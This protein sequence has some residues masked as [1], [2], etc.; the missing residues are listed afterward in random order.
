M[1][2]LGVGG[3]LAYLGLQNRE[4]DLAARAEEEYKAGQ[5][6]SAAAQ[7]EQL[8]T[9]FPSSEDH[10]RYQFR[11]DLAR[12]RARVGDTESSEGLTEILDHVDRVLEEHGNDPLLEELGPDLGQAV[13]KLLTDFAER[14]ANNPSDEK[15]LEVITR[16]GSTLEALGKVPKGTGL[17]REQRQHI[18]E[19]FAQVRASLDRA[20]LRRE[21]LE[22]LQTV[23]RRPS[24]Q[25]IRETQAIVRRYESTFPG[26]ASEDDVRNIQKKLYD[27]HLD[28]VRYVAEPVREQKQTSG[29]E[30]EPGLI[31]DPVLHNGPIAPAGEDS[32]VLALTRGV[33]YA[34]RRSTGQVKWALRVGIDT[35]VLPVRV[36]ASVGSRERI[37][38]LSSDTATLRALDTEGNTLW[39]YRLDSPC[40]GRPVVV[41]QRAY[42]PTVNGQVHEI[43]LA[44]GRL[45]G[46][47]L[48]QPRL[49]RGGTLEP[50][51]HRIY[52]PADEGCVYVLDVEKHRCELILY[53]G[54]QAGSLRSEAVVVAPE[55]RGEETVPGYLILPTSQGLQATQL[56]VFDLPLRDR[57]QTAR[58][59]Q[60]RAGLEGWIW[61]KPYQ[62]PEKLVLLSDAARLGVYGIRQTG[63]RDE[64]L[65]PLVPDGS[66]D[67]R[68]LL[69]NVE[70]RGA[71]R[72]ERAEVVQIQGEDLWVLATGWLQRLRLGWSASQGPRLVQGWRVPLELGSP[73]HDS[74]VHEDPLTGRSVLYL[75]TRAA[76]HPGCLAS[77]V[78][79]E[80]GHIRWQRQLGFV[81]RGDPLPLQ[82]PGGASVLVAVDEGGGLL[83]LDP[84][85]FP[86]RDAAWQRLER[87]GHLAAGLAENPEA[88][89]ILIPSPT[90]QAVY[91]LSFPPGG[92]E[93][94]IRQVGPAPEGRRL[95][96][97]EH[98]VSLPFR[99]AGTPAVVGS[100]L[101]L[102]LGDGTLVRIPLPIPAGEVSPESGPEWRANRAGP[103]SRGHVV[104]LGGNRF[105]TTD[106]A[107]GLA[108][109]SWPAEQRDW[110][111][112]PA[113][114]DQ[115]TLELKDYIVAPPVCL[116]GPGGQTMVA[117]ADA[118]GNLHLLAVQN[119]GGL[120]IAQT[121]RLDG[122]VTN[123]PFVRTVNGKV[124]LGCVVEET[125]LVWLEPGVERPRWQY[126][127]PAGSPIVGQPW[128]MTATSSQ[129]GKKEAGRVLIVVADA[130]RTGQPG[131]YVGL[132]PETGK[133]VAP[134]YALKGSVVPTA[135]PLP[136]GENRLLAP[137]SDGTALF[138]AV[139]RLL[140]SGK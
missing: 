121:W 97:V 16:A 12:I 70:G 102:P 43:E 84:A 37:L 110:H 72:H 91:A 22:A 3:W 128:P 101:I 7:F 29:E 48:L 20:R 125:R 93:L 15:S 47:F 35:T 14:A 112:L 33:L 56:R 53:S 109:W 130:G 8:A 73:L 138:L 87:D 45:L 95:R 71:A 6:R 68:K 75:V 5:Y 139:E 85:R 36:P 69:T 119:D 78:E 31:V 66:V 133:P 106:G 96:G 24:Y 51:T 27:D 135:T 26:L 34:L 81:C 98:R 99:P 65:F 127:T 94:V 100:Q 136:F 86:R 62:D 32:I 83:A 49:T 50:G 131:R 23:A 76:H 13:E 39:R 55:V 67:L 140:P 52:F 59:L 104:D 63:N 118:G 30:T 90:G 120:K 88:P 122:R 113:G 25:A 117:V 28:S 41:A 17:S 64:A 1:V 123:G 46:R 74:Q 107:R 115:L 124:Q 129:E 4:R 19:G 79:D 105:L 60:P 108:C 58:A 2:A 92:S 9:K 82:L 61:F 116:S 77:A 42:L 18:Q 44:E 54:H 10:P 103:E 57:H 40:L 21:I 38:V 11:A 134:G 126:E 137:L 132:D 80:T 111:P 114:R 89:T